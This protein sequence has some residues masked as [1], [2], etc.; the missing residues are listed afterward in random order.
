MNQTVIIPTLNPTPGIVPLVRELQSL[1]FA[2]I[3]VVDDG[4]E[5]SCGTLFAELENLGA[6]VVH[7]E[8][9]EGKGAAIKTGIGTALDLFPA[10]TGFVTVD[11]DGQHLPCDVA[12]VCQKAD[13]AP[14]AVVL[15]TRNFKQAGVPVRSRLG[16]AFSSLYFLLDTGMR[17]ADTQTGLRFI[18]RHL[19]DFALNVSGTRYE[20]EMN[21]L[22]K[23][24][25]GGMNVQF[26][27]I[28]TVY[29]DNNAGSHFDTVRDSLRIFASL[30]RF[31]ASSLMSTLVD[32]A[33]FALFMALANPTFALAIPVSTMLARFASGAIN[34]TLNRR[35]SFGSRGKA[36][37]QAARY[38]IL[39][40]S[41]MAASAALV[42]S[43]SW[44]P[45]PI[46]VVKMLVDSCLF[47]VSYVVQHNWVF[48]D[49]RTPLSQAMEGAPVL[50][51][52]ADNSEHQEPSPVSR[53]T[54]TH[55]RWR[56][57]Q[58]NGLGCDG[59]AGSR[60]PLAARRR[61][62]PWAVAYSVAL[63]AF[64]GYTLFDTFAYQRVQ[65]QADQV[66]TSSIVAATS[67]A[68]LSENST[69][70]TSADSASTGSG[71][72]VTDAS[73]SDDDMQIS[74]STQRV[75]D[76]DVY[77]VDVQVSS[78]E[79]LKTALANAQFGRNIKQTTSAMATDN[80][81]V[82]AINGDYYG[83]HDDGYVIRN[84]VL[85]RSTASTGTDALVVYGDGTL[86]AAD[87]DQ[88]TAQQLLD[89]GAWQVLSFGPVLVED[90][91][92]AVSQNAEVDQAKTSN[93]RTAIGMISPLHYVIVVSD[94]RTSQSEG[95]SLYQLAQVFQDQGCTFAYN[96]DGGGSTTLWFNGSV[97]NNP[98][99]GHSTG[100]RQVSDIVYF[101]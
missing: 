25:K 29:Q 23:A 43:L 68:S 44:L 62:L 20:Y 5:E 82:L 53:N 32:L 38:A 69:A 50:A 101:G 47:A 72:I 93:P 61:F 99:D 51:D 13:T 85:Y 86:A 40:V 7:H 98:T 27:P 78:A 74:I 56:T 100:E 94:G 88:V 79:Y 49:D 97:V 1:E 70:E 26:V 83:F 6:Y 65:A 57:K 16:N 41:I 66:D 46:V 73:Y 12:R 90:S 4:S 48:A 9:N 67:T 96:L 17:C 24:V 39:F 52:S 80:N 55:G 89:D 81:A 33:L 30:A 21:F 34:F 63:V 91:Q 92:I 75:S 31:T 87:E 11:G 22:I 60:R 2:R 58:G 54:R 3:V 10:T 71:A 59:R 36:D 35:W 42:W 18:P 77:I 37:T 14:N 95:L 45:L 15:G 28:Q 8:A 76:T 19:A 64:T 84:G